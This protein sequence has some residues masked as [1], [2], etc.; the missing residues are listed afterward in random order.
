MK[1]DIPHRVNTAQ[2]VWRRGVHA[3]ELSKVLAERVVAT[4][5]HSTGRAYRR[6]SAIPDRP[7]G[8]HESI[9]GVPEKEL[10]DADGALVFGVG[11]NRQRR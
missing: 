1:V 10:E 7:K 11:Y 6:H 9:S 8:A 4:V 5:A 3:E 2:G